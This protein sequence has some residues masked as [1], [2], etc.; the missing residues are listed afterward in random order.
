MEAF[1]RV[2]NKKNFYNIYF[3]NFISFL[4]WS[5]F[6]NVS[7]LRSLG[8]IH[9]LSEHMGYRSLQNFHSTLYYLYS[10]IVHK[11]ERGVKR[12][13]SCSC[14]LWIPPNYFFSSKKGF[15]YEKKSLSVEW[16]GVL[17]CRLNNTIVV[18][19]GIDTTPQKWNVYC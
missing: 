12:P 16:C 19:C 17:W 7:I 5:F 1:L 15:H 2:L 4:A 3:F 11:E 6:L 13:K 8:G 18:W 9:E 10:K 14:S